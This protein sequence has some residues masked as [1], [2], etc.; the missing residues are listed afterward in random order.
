MPPTRAPT[1]VTGDA[2]SCPTRQE[3]YQRHYPPRCRQ[4]IDEPI[5]QVALWEAVRIALLVADDREIISRDPP[6]DSPIANAIDSHEYLLRCPFIVQVCHNEKGS[7]GR[8]AVQIALLRTWIRLSTLRDIRGDG[9]AVLVCLFLAAS[10]GWP[11]L[12]SIG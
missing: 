4:V 12:G 11:I 6:G 9:R 8:E 3:I 7:S 5:D 1:A 2:G 10:F